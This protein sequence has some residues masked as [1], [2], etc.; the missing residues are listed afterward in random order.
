MKGLCFYKRIN[1]LNEK[2]SIKLNYN[3]L[4]PGNPLDTVQHFPHS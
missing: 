4:I 1:D 3:F 2:K